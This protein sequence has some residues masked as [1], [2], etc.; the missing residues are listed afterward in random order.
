[1]KNT[2]HQ[3]SCIVFVP[4]EDCPIPAGSY[5]L[6]VDGSGILKFRNAL[7]LDAVANLAWIG[8]ASG[9]F[10]EGK[11]EPAFNDPVPPPPAEEAE[12]LDARRAPRRPRAS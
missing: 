5:G 10:V 6:W 8:D 3:A 2:P 7:G 12:S 11:K 4:H 9:S 1:M